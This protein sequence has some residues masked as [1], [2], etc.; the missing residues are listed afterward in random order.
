MIQ[1]IQKRIIETT[2]SILLMILESG[3]VY[4]V[5]NSTIMKEE[6][7]ELEISLVSLA[8]LIR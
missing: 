3:V 5:I 2:Q 8:A 7:I 1:D 4:Y 6:D